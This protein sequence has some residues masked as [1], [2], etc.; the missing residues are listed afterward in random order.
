MGQVCPATS[1]R[2]IIPADLPPQVGRRQDQPDNDVVRGLLSR[3]SKLLSDDMAQGVSNLW[4]TR[5]WSLPPV[6]RV[7]V[8]IMSITVTHEFTAGLL[9]FTDERLPLHT[10]SSTGCCWAVF[11][12]GERSWVTIKS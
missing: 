3:E 2:R 5:H 9:Q 6:G 7:A 1:N 4:M 12:A 11:G 10:S 8:D